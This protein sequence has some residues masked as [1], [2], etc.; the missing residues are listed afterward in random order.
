MES[1]H[2]EAARPKGCGLALGGSL[3]LRKQVKSWLFVSDLACK[4][5]LSE[6]ITAW[7]KS[8]QTQQELK[9][10]VN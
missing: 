9:K 10:I 2:T 7:P 3:V 4:L 6:L 5:H 8:S 1:K